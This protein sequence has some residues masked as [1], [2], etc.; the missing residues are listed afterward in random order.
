MTSI[1][2]IVDKALEK[3]EAHLHSGYISPSSLGQCYRRQ[4]WSRSNEP[5]T[6]PADER[7]LRVFKCGYMFEKFV[8]DCLLILHPEWKT[9]VKVVQDDIYGYADIVTSDEVIDTKSQNSRKFWW[10]IKD[11]KAGKD[12]KEMFYNNWL[13]VMAYALILGKDRAR[14][15]YISKDDLCIQEYSLPLDDYWK[16]ELAKE[17]R[18]IRANWETKVLPPAEPRLYGG[19]E[20]KKE[21]GY[22]P[23]KDKCFTLEKTNK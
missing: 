14:L 9:Q 3:K 22:C 23:F 4:F 15:C 20:T 21:C 2:E 18:A 16:G 12:I 11:M 6:N 17:Y 1:Q 5:E 7:S 8:I 19:K 10:N 13:Q